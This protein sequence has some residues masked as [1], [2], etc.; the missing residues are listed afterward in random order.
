MHKLKLGEESVPVDEAQGI[1]ELIQ[2]GVSEAQTMI[3]SSEKPIPRE[4]HPKQ[5][6]CVWAEFTVEKNLPDYLQ[7]GIFKQPKT[8]S[9][10]IRFSSRREQFDQKGDVSYGMAIKLMDIVH[11]SNGEKANTQDF[12]MTNHPVFFIKDVR[13]YIVSRKEKTELLKPLRLAVKLRPFRLSGRE[14]QIAGAQILKRQMKIN[15]P[16]E[17]QYWSMVPYRFGLEKICQFWSTTPTEHQLRAIKFFVKPRLPQN[18]LE[19]KIPKSENY[20]RA[21]M[22]TFLAQQDAYFDFYVQLQ[23]DPDRHPIEDPR[24]EWWGGPEYKVATIRIPAQT[25]DTTDQHEFSEHLSFTP[26]HCLPEHQPLGGI[27]RARR[28]V[29]Q[30]GSILRHRANQVRLEEPTAASSA[31]YKHLIDLP[32]SQQALTVFV[33]IKAANVEK[34]KVC[35]AELSDEIK[36]KLEQTPATHFLRWVVI[37]DSTQD[38]EPHLL[39]TSNYDGELDAYLKQLREA[40]DIQMDQIWQHCEGYHEGTAKDARSLSEF[41]EQYRFQEQVFGAACPNRTVQTIRDSQKVRDLLDEL[42]DCPGVQEKIEQLQGLSQQ[43]SRSQQS[44]GKRELPIDDVLVPLLERLVGIKRGYLEPNKE[45]DLDEDRMKQVRMTED[46]IAQNEMTIF[47]AIK[48]GMYAWMLLWLTLQ[49]TQLRIREG[50]SSILK[51]KTIHFARWV[52]MRKGR[53]GHPKSHFLLFESNYNGNWDSY[54]GQF[55]ETVASRLNCIWG[56]CIEYPIGGSQDENWFKQHIRKYQFPAQIFYSAYPDLTVREIETNLQI[57]D[58]VTE[59]CTQ[60]GVQNFLSGVY[61]RLI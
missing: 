51:L 8:Y 58:L 19:T 40:I 17:I 6:G 1:R 29:Y 13:D 54:I 25:F 42:I 24:I 30:A 16:L 59:F 3:R 50:R 33:P 45:L 46:T 14:L 57:Y 12:L 26:W 39:F 21:A 2:M 61:N 38:F 32:K 56:N 28:E 49:L 47:V 18:R 44:A 34:L 60:A 52:M 31:R 9:A 22:T 5:F 48:P 7:A 11:K 41:I 20:L 53:L 10:W 27:N 35:L 4:Q 23:T 37:D 43:R 36:S 55:I 15:S